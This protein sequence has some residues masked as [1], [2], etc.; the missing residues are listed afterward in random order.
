MDH[1]I[2]CKIKVDS[3][4]DVVARLGEIGAGFVG[5][6]LLR[7]AYFD[8]A[9]DALKVADCGLRIRR[10]IGDD[11]EKV[12][13]TYKGPRQ[14]NPFKSRQEVETSVG[15]FEFMSKILLALGMKTN[16]VIEKKRDL[17]LYRGCEVCLD[18]LPLLG[19]FVE[20]EG[21]NAD[22]IS[23]V[24]EALSLSGLEHIDDGYARLVSDKLEELGI[25][26]K[27]VIFTDGN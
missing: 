21:E 13:V 2:E 17:W 20:V 1:E 8:F 26:D 19:T 7:D 24:L 4:A 22:K 3:H 25:E 15:E 14:D 10:Q 6:F 11:G 9:G 27:E 5:S 16:I 18:E 12:I 23:A